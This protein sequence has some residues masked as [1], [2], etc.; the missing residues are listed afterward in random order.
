MGKEMGEQINKIKNFSR[1]LNENINDKVI[2]N[3]EYLIKDVCDNYDLNY[4]MIKKVL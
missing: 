1:F 4:M 2:N 3:L